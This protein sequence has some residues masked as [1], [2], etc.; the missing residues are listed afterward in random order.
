MTRRPMIQPDFFSLFLHP[1][2]SIEVPYMI[3]GAVASTIYG[4]P[5]LTQDID[6]VLD[7]DRNGVPRLATAFPPDQYYVPPEEALEE[8]VGRPSGGHFNLLHLETG[9]RA[10][11]YLAGGDEFSRWGLDHRRVDSVAGEPI[12]IAPPEYVIVRKLEYR[13]QGAGEHHVEDVARMLR[14]SRALIDQATLDGWIA[15]VGVAQEWKD[16]LARLARMV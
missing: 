13:R 12:S 7:L 10:D 9:L 3:T 11:C 16:A 4:E 14:V 15:R 8:E 6:I 1:L 5:R 2:N